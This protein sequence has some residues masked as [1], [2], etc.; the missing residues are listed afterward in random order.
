MSLIKQTVYTIKSSKNTQITVAALN[1][2]MS[3]IDIVFIPRGAKW[4]G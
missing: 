3:L 1:V 2:G 4:L